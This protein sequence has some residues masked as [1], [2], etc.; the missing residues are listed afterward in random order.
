MLCVL[1]H[2]NIT[3]YGNNAQPVA[4]GQCCDSC[5]FG[6]VLQQ[7]LR[8]A[9]LSHSN[10]NALPNDQRNGEQNGPHEQK[11]PHRRP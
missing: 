1:C 4:E 8:H 11:E 6:V 9:L 2:D 5:N 7:R 10:G 3:G